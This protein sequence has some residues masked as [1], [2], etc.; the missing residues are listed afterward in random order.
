M[1]KEVIYN[2]WDSELPKIIERE[3]KINTKTDLINDIVG[4]RRSGKTCLMF[5]TINQLLSKVDKKATIYINFENRRLLPLTSDY[6]NQ[7]ISFIYQEELLEKHKKIYLFLDEIQRIAE[8][9]KFIRGIYD[10]FKG[11]IKIFVSGSSADLLS[12]EYGK[13]LTGRHLTIGV[14]PLSFKE[15]LRFKK[16]EADILSEKKIAQIKKLLEEYL[17][18]GGFPEIVLQKTKKQKEALLNQLFNDVL[19]RD[20]LGRTEARK[21]QLLEE[22]AYFLSSNIANLLSFNKMARYF[23]SRG[24]KISVPTLINY[25][26]LAKGSF[27]FFDSS[28]FSYKVK[29]QLQYPRKIYCIDN[30]LTNLIGF[31]FSPNIGR[32]YENAIAIE[33]FR[34]FFHQPRI[35]FFYWKNLRDQEVDF[36]IK[37][38]LKVKQLIQV[39]S[40]Y[41]DPQTKSRELRGLLKA[42]QELKCGNLLVITSD[43]ETE[44]KIKGKKIKFVPL[45]KWLLLGK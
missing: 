30:G 44:E 4:V 34:K 6:F 36:V 26:S 35:K 1:L 28:I 38:G 42:S 23:N 13:L 9:E 24:V 14:F 39:C 40:H 7:L 17:E 45:W 5:G 32:L 19:S 18:F 25:F 21:E 37:D 31:K 20:V 29:D 10:E 12:K 2:Y 43:I 11:R 22:F 41:E 8:W 3:D 15:F 27:L 16:F 33:L